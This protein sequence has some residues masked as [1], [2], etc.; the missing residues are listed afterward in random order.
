MSVRLAVSTGGTGGHVF[1]ALAV[2][3]A[4]RDL[5]PGAEVLFFGGPGPE[6]GMAEKA[7]V[8]FV[9]LP[10]RGVLGTGREKLKAP[11]WMAKALFLSLIRLRRFRPQVVIG[12]GGYAGF[13]P[14]L[15]AWMLGIPTAVHEQNSVPGLV[16]RVLARVVD[17]VF[18]SFPE[19]AARFPE[20]KTTVTGNPVRQDI[21]ALGREPRPAG[22]RNLLVLGGSQGAR[23]VNDLVAEAAPE[24]LARGV[25]LR[26][27]TGRAD[28]GRVLA[29][30]RKRGVD[31]KG[32]VPFIEDMA[33]ALRWAD[34]VLC[35][36]G[37]STVFEAAAG[38][39]A[40]VFIPF[41]HATHDHQRQNAQA[42][43]QAGG[44]LVLEQHGL[45]DLVLA[46]TLCGLLEDAPRLEGMSRAALSFSRPDAARDLARLAL[47]LADNA[48]SRP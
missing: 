16:N 31:P 25:R 43:A 26:H 37:A 17:R 1:P 19:T 33:G 12:F 28:I 14:P 41:P 7:D 35:R 38:G 27:Q 18:V 48:R 5:C 22:G 40:C 15:A 9:A 21:A 13:C 30:Y 32:V 42:L 2:A 36:A 10:A 8:P 45:T 39:R 20:A 29:L 6:A 46:R 47:S 24:L 3:R 34:L 11:L 4:V 44:A 23:A